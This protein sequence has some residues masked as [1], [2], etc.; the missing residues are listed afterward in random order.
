MLNLDWIKL[1]C[2]ASIIKLPKFSTTMFFGR[3]GFLASSGSLTLGTEEWLSK[4]LWGISEF[5]G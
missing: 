3:S 2:P 5:G 4:G 1:R